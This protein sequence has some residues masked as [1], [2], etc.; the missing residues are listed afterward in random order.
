MKRSIFSRRFLLAVAV[1]LVLF[2]GMF[3]KQTRSQTSATLN[4]VSAAAQAVQYQFTN[5]YLKLGAEERPVELVAVALPQTKVAVETPFVGDLSSFDN[6]SLTIK[7]T[8]GQ[9]IQQVALRLTMYGLDGKQADVV[10][11][12][13]IG[14]IEQGQT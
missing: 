14:E 3:W 11:G 13:P 2:S 12:H 5:D 1:A 9:K 6:A 4:V 8:S 10:H 7:N